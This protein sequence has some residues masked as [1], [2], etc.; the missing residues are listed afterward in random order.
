M[1]T[2]GPSSTKLDP[3]LA[4]AL[5][6]LG[7]FVTGLILLAV[8]RDSRYVRFHAMQSTALFVGV[9]IV[10][11]AINSLLFLGAFLFSFVLFPAVV[12]IWLVLMF[13]AYN[14]EKYKLPVVGDFAERRT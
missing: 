2:A 12:V 4:A 7:G 8:E 5:A 11:I 9:L 14:G 1:T 3:N 10:S 6:Y 13:K